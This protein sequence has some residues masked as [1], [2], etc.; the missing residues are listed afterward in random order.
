MWWL[1][2][3]ALAK[4]KAMAAEFTGIVAGFV[5]ACRASDTKATVTPVVVAGMKGQANSRGSGAPGLRARHFPC[6]MCLTNEREVQVE[7]PSKKAPHP[8]GQGRMPRARRDVSGSIALV[9]A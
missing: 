1:V 2:K 5:A 8:R 6:S 9:S 7:P 3:P 4:Q